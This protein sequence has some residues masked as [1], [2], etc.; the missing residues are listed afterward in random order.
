MGSAP[1]GW[2]DDAGL[3]DTTLLVTGDR[4][5]TAT[6]RT[7]FWNRAI[8]EVLRVRPPTLP[9]PP[10]TP[11]VELGDDGV[12]RTADG[13][14]LRPAG[15][16]RAVDARRSRA[17]RSPSGRRRQQRDV[18]VDGVA[19][20]RA[21]CASLRRVEGLLPNGD[22]SGPRHGSR[23]IA[24]RPGT[25]DVT[26]PRQDRRSDLARTSTGS[27]SRRS[28]RRPRSRRRTRIPAPPYADGTRPC[29]F[30]LE[31]PG[32]A[33][34][35]TID[36]TPRLS[37]A[38]SRGTG[39]RARSAPRSR[40][41]RRPAP[42]PARAGEPAR[43]RA[44]R[45][46]RRPR[47]RASPRSPPVSRS[48]CELLR[49]VDAACDRDLDELGHAPDPTSSS[50]RPA[51]RRARRARA[52]RA[53]AAGPSMRSKSRGTTVAGKILAASSATSDPA[54]RA[55]RCV[56]ASRRDVRLARDERRVV[57]G[58]VVRLPRPVPLVGRGTSPRGR[59]RRQPRAASTTDARRRRVAGEHDRAALGAVARATSS[60]RTTRPAS[61]LTASPRCSAP[62][63]GPSGTPSASA[64]STSKRPGRPSS[65]SA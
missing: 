55:E 2:L 10:V 3:E 54:Y 16:R 65:R 33:G 61:R 60:G 37:R 21:R 52:G 15:R 51:G 6:A 22:F 24:C 63:A 32:Y 4:L 27:R 56:S 53:R 13:G 43:R 38:A 57:G 44:R 20:G 59:E 34:T 36:F 48:A 7:I 58:R 14:P 35:T 40:H 12:L 9:F 50:P 11:A 19:A 28:R 17:R 23:S 31:N 49:L 18:R 47:P 8:D 62:R 5:W 45:D 39:R 46:A 26:D 30:E 25:L 29:I 41:A 42:R 1:G 64:A